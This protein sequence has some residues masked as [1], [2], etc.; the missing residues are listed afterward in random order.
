[1]VGIVM[2]WYNHC[3]LL[4][5]EHALIGWVMLANGSPFSS[6]ASA[7]RIQ[8]GSFEVG[9]N[10]AWTLEFLLWLELWPGTKQPLQ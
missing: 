3:V 1:M 5:L 4:I 8:K 9:S 6:S 7:P 2:Q 10:S